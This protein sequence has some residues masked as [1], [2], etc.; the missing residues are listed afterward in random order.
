MVSGVQPQVVQLQPVS[1]ASSQVKPAS[2]RLEQLK[3]QPSWTVR[4]SDVPQ[5]QPLRSHSGAMSLLIASVQATESESNMVTMSLA[6]YAPRQAWSQG[7]IVVVSATQQPEQSQQC[8]ASSS[9][10]VNPNSSTAVSQVM[11][12]P[13]TFSRQGS[14]HKAA[15][16]ERNDKALRAPSVKLLM[17][18][19]GSN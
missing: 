4:Q 17:D 3:P 8:Q 11:K 15:T 6:E 13:L 1:K 7:A 5:P 14:E 2:M 16:P 9:W 12:V 10:H 18:L 19:N